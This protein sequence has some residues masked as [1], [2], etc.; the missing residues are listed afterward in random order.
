MS[1]NRFCTISDK[2]R[3]KKTTN[4]Q[5]PK[6]QKQKNFKSSVSCHCMCMLMHSETMPCFKAMS[7]KASQVCRFVFASSVEVRGGKFVQVQ[8]PIRVPPVKFFFEHTGLQNVFCFRVIATLIKHSTLTHTLYTHVMWF[9]NTDGLHLLNS[10]P[11]L[12]VAPLT[13]FRHYIMGIWASPIIVWSPSAKL[14][15]YSHSKIPAL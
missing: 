7:K 1:R 2:K 9:Q 5:N 10:N 11:D 6:T 13:K 8:T 4:K 15:V 3:K 14:D 12:G